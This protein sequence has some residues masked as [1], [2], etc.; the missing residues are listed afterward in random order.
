MWSHV[1]H[2]DFISFTQSSGQQLCTGLA[3]LCSRLAGRAWPAR[4][5]L[6]HVI[7]IQSAEA[8]M[9]SVSLVTTTSGMPS[10]PLHLALTWLPPK[11]TGPYCQTQTAGQRTLRYPT[12]LGGSTLQRMCLSSTACRHRLSRGL[13][14]PLRHQQKLA[15]YSEACMAEGICLLV[16]EAH[17]SWHEEAVSILKRLGQA[18]ARA[19]GG[20][21]AEVVRHFFM[22]LSVLLMKDN[23]TF[24]RIPL[25]VEP[26][27]DGYL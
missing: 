7:I 17:G 18:L 23:G 5:F 13:Q 21:E 22:W 11:R 12:L 19:T 26:A 3:C 27:V 16:V 24:H 2:L 1:Q 8:V 4:N 20:N 25:V 10:L 15:K 14:L 9:V 6:T